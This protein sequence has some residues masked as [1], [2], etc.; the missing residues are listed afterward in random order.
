MSATILKGWVERQSKKPVRL[1]LTIIAPQVS[2]KIHFSCGSAFLIP[3][4]DWTIAISISV[5]SVLTLAL[6]RRESF[7]SS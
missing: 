2:P 3:C 6:T 4:V 1:K 7:C 5:S